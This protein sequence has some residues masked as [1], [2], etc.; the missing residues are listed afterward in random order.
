MN[1]ENNPMF[2]GLFSAFAL[3]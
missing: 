2:Q 1:A 3:L